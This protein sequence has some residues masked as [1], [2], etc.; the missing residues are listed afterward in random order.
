MLKEQID[1]FKIADLEKQNTAL[2]QEKTDLQEEV[3]NL[4]NKIGVD[5]VQENSNLENT[6]KV[7]RKLF[8]SEQNNKNQTRNE[9]QILKKDINRL[10]DNEQK[11]NAR[12]DELNLDL[13]TAETN[14]QGLQTQLTEAQETITSLQ[15]EL[16]TFDRLKERL[17]VQTR[18]LNS[19]NEENTD[20]LDDIQKI[21][22]LKKENSDLIN[23]VQRLTSVKK[24][25]TDTINTMT[26]ENKKLNQ[27]LAN[28][29]K[30]TQTVDREKYQRS[31]KSKTTLI[32]SLSV[33]AGLIVIPIISYFA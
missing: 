17:E 25:L 23:D 12:F 22:S 5:L 20:L 2:V 33:V 16:Q 1:D 27:D 10:L 21:A 4:K 24:S 14:L 15:T 13:K 19:L 32:V 9:N 3:K 30:T 8:Q 29:S 6:I 18:I 31:T 7:L 26:E 28:L 11:R